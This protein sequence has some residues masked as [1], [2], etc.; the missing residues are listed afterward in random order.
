MASPA[1]KRINLALQ[2]GGAH[3]AFTW[4]VLDWLLEDNR[5]HIDGLTGTSAGAMNAVVLA[6]GFQENGA[7]GAREKLDQFWWEVSQQAFLSPIKRSPI[8]VAMGQW[9]LDFSPSYLAFDLMSRFSSPYEFNPLN[10]N[11]L[12]DVVDRVVDFD[13]V[14]Q[15]QGLRLFVAATN[16]YSGK[17]R[18]FSERDVNLDAVMASACLPHL[19]QAVEIDGEPYW[20]GGYMGNPPLYPLFYNTGTPDIVLIQINPVERRETPKTA[21][22]IL[23][24]VNEITFNSTLLRELRAVDFVSRLIEDEKLS[25]EQY[26]KVHVHRITA[27]ELK[28]LQASSKVNA[29]WAF[30]TELKSIGRN[31]A[32][33]WVD[34]NFDAVGSHSTVNL[35]Q[36]FI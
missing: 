25:A 13:R 18:V 3:G 4:G 32:E 9:S 10:I 31:A 15:C 21:R 35:R 30:L 17:I 34:Q 29:E 33:S 11:P 7:E 1:P 36:E 26:M 20:D 19:F 27:D 23:N 12:R 2:G 22:E 28:P 5:F 16:V 14:H 6:S 24:R 8:D